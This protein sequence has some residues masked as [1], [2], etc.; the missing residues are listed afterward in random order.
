MLELRRY[1]ALFE[2]PSSVDGVS[3]NLPG[4]HARDILTMG[5]WRY[6]RSVMSLTTG[7]NIIVLSPP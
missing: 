3:P 6:A 7:C 5:A 2:D 4:L 1:L